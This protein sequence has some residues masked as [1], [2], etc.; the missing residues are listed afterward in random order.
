VYDPTFHFLV[1]AEIACAFDTP[2]PSAR[3]QRH[4]RTAQKYNIQTRG[5]SAK[6]HKNS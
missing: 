6:I 2:P 1:D 5:N 4:A 3:A